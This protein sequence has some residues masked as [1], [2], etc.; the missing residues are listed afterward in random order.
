MQAKQPTALAG[1]IQHLPG[2]RYVAEAYRR[3]PLGTLPRQAL[4]MLRCQGGSEAQDELGSALF[5]M[6]RGG[7]EN[8][9]SHC[10]VVWPHHDQ[11]SPG[12][13]CRAAT[14]PRAARCHSTWPLLRAGQKFGGAGSRLDTEIW[15]QWAWLS[16]FPTIALV[17]TSQAITG[18][19]EKRIGHKR[20]AC[21]FNERTLL[22]EAWAPPLQSFTNRNS[23]EQSQGL[24]SLNVPCAPIQN[25]Y[26]L[27]RELA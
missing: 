20:T 13:N 4:R 14:G 19:M 9:G 16:S 7:A 22:P 21:F 8:I 2:Q 11:G 5:I 17:H 27:A 3:A 6:P 12:A 24:L 23:G 18:S 26:T 25:I 15:A 1:H 10:S